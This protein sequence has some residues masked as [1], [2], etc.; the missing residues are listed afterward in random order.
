MPETGQARIVECHQSAPRNWG[1]VHRER[2]EPAAREV[3]L[4]DQSVVAGAQN[5]AVKGRAHH[6]I[7]CRSNREGSNRAATPSG[8][9][10]T[11]PKATRPSRIWRHAKP[12][13]CRV[14]R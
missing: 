3:S 12:S 6:G 1:A 14:K 4:Q 8:A 13:R 7:T 2:P 10:F 11:E 5:D 9:A